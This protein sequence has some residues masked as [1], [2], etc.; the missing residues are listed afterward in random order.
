[1]SSSL[2]RAVARQRNRANMA[3]SRLSTSYWL[4]LA[5]TAAAAIAGIATWMLTQPRE[6]SST[7]KA[8]QRRL[9]DSRSGKSSA[10][11]RQDSVPSIE[12]EQGEDIPSVVDDETKVTPQSAISDGDEDSYATENTEKAEEEAQ[13]RTDAE[14]A[15]QTKRK[16]QQIQR[17]QQRQTRTKKKLVAVV[18]STDPKDQVEDEDGDDDSVSNIQSVSC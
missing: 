17:S 6:S 4:P 18:V 10:Q 3:L 9:S 12:R 8:S 2:D 15:K 16:A 11:G 7:E 13:A 1:M 14:E 5:I